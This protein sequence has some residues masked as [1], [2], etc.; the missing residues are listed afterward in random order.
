MS[1][2]VTVAAAQLGPIGRDEPRDAVVERLLTLL[3]DASR[4]GAALVVYPEL[5]LTTFFPRWWI[6]PLADADRWFETEMPGAATKP[7]FDEAAALGV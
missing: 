5:A 4:R 2:R 7:L 3:H 1:R 6:E